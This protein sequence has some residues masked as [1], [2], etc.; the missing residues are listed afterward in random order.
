MRTRIAFPIL[1]IGLLIGSFASAQVKI[2]DNPQTIDPASVLELESTERVLVITR[3]DSIQMSNIVPNRGALVYNTSADCVFYYNGTDW[4]NLC[5]D[6]AVGGLTTDPI[7][8]PQATIVITPTPNGGNIEIAKSSINSSMIIDGGI[9]G[10][11]IQNGSIGR[12][13]LQNSSVDRTKLAENSVGPYAIDN[14]SIDLSDFNNSTGFIRDTDLISGDADNAIVAGADGGAYY[15]DSGLQTAIAA[16]TAG[17][18]ADGDTDA[19]NEIQGLSISGNQLSLSLG[20]GLV[21]LPTSN[22]SETNIQPTGN[23]IT[24]SGNGTAGTPFIIDAENEVDGDISNELITAS[25]LNGNILTL[26][27]G[28][29]LFNIDLTGLGGGGSAPTVINSTPSISVLGDGSAATPYE[30]ATIGTSGG[31]T[32]EEVDGITLSGFGTP[33]DPFTIVPGGDGQIL[34]TVGTDVTWAD[35]PTGG[36]GVVAPTAAEVPVTTNPIN[37]TAITQDVEAHLVGI[38]LAL[39]SGGGG[40]GSDNQTAA[41]VP[42]APY[43]SILSNNVQAAVQELKDEL[44]A[45]PSGGGGGNQDLGQVLTQGNDGGG[46]LIKNIGNPEDDQDAAT[47]SYVDGAITSGGTPLNDGNFLIGD[48]TNAAQPVA[49]S[50]DATIDN[51]GVL[52]IAEAAITLEKLNQMGAAND[53]V[54]KWDGTAWAPAADAGGTPYTDG[55]G[56]TLTD[57][58]FS[59]DD[60]AGEVTGP[61]SATVIAGNAVTSA[62]IANATIL[63]EDLADMGAANDQVLKWNGTGWAPAADAGG[64]P[65][66]PGT[67]L[68][69]TG[70]DFN[71]VD[72]A[73]EVTGPTSATVIAGNAVTSAKIANATILAEDL[74]DM[75]AANDQVLKWNGTEWAP[76]ADSGGT[77]YT[78]GTGLTLTGT[79]FNVVDL[80]GEVSGP[81]SATVIAGNAVTSA[82]IAN[83]TILAEDLADMGAA[84]DQV[85]KWNGTE[86]APAADSGGTPYTP[87]TGLTLTGTDFNVVD[88][89][90]EVSGPTSATVIAGNAVTSAKIANATILAEDLANMGAANDQVLKWNGTA[91]APAADAGFVFTNTDRIIGDGTSGDPLTIR[92]D[93][94]TAF[95]LANDAVTIPNIADANVTPAKI[96]P[97]PTDGEVLTTVGGNVVWAAGETTTLSSDGSITIVKTGNNYD[98]S[99]GEISGGFGGQITDDSITASD[100]QADSVDSQEIKSGAVKTGEI[101]DGTITDIDINAGAAIDGTKI[102]PNFGPQ[103]ISTTG[104]VTV[105]VTIVHP[106]YVFEKY[107]KDSS[108]LK[109]TYN[110]KTLEEIETFIKKNHHL[111]GIKSAEQVKKDG[112]WNLSE[113]NLQNLEKIEELYLHTI[114]QEKK[115]NQLQSEKE[116]LSDE[117][118]ALRN[119]LEEIKTMLKKLK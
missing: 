73:G 93:A 77:P 12:G 2:G 41:Q 11:D 45:L 61:T 31:G 92:N 42:F 58:V 9:N 10:I 25:E 15:D 38:D 48:A 112:F 18:A 96:Q 51:T 28:G 82:K 76:A 35:L 99:V 101:F 40:G 87:G 69:L 7:V 67:G 81:T 47:K 85:L 36:G 17:I 72:L 74:A 65:Y 54:L 55:D 64:T 78:P 103:D 21:T 79:D 30:L 88:L 89:V 71:V 100:L 22:G 32:T 4:I 62:K 115:I 8:N 39:A 23:R 102:N 75:G 113:S 33:L 94:I 5:G 19:G 90:G 13:K 26:T 104:S 114:E 91:W 98:L 29:N 108:K 63:A 24:V 50:G 70:T 105:G 44:D 34:T 84:N 53:Q 37:Y 97:S 80:V 60:L 3:V 117:V 27:E 68:T 86:W 1:I 116:V 43:Q 95:E 118:K 83:A 46:L 56:I 57:N 110:F 59:A 20:G 109:K 111:P 14:D 106:D 16:N 49:I 119:D 66:T 52:T 6:G 107:F